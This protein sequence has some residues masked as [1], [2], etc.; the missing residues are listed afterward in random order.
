[1]VP[2]LGPIIQLLFLQTKMADNIIK[3]TILN[4]I[5]KA[6]LSMLSEFTLKNYGINE[7]LA[8]VEITG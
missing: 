4:V 8:L 5:V 6:I 7:N 1:M 2:A 3:D